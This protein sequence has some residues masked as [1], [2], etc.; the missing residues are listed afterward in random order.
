M[1]LRE[2]AASRSCALKW[3]DNGRWEGGGR[4]GLSCDEGVEM[5]KREAVNADWGGRTKTSQSVNQ[6]NVPIKA[7]SWKSQR[8]QRSSFG[9]K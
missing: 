8:F 9:L 7:V 6:P 1:G 4:L 2:G 5:V 3:F